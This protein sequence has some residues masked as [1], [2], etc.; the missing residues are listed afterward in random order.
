MTPI[1]YILSK[2]A[3]KAL[4]G[5]Q[6]CMKLRALSIGDSGKFLVFFPSDEQVLEPMSRLSF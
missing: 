3:P 1:F 2:H 6:P 5:K 4:V